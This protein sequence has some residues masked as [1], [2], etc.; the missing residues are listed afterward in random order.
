MLSRQDRSKEEKTVVR[1]M[2]VAIED[3]CRGEHLD[4]RFVGGMS[5]GGLLNN[6]TTYT[7]DV[8][9][10]RITLKNHNPL[11]LLRP[12]KS[13]RDIDFIL[14]S[15]APEKI[16]PLKRFLN[17]LKWQIRLKLSYTPPISFEGLAQYG[18]KPLGLLRFVTTMQIQRGVAY[19]VFDKISQAVSPE[20][21]EAWTVVLEDGTAYTTRNPIADY[22][23][24]QFRSPAGIKPKDHDKVARLKNL[25]DTMIVEGK[26]H[27]IDYMS[28]EYFAPWQTFIDDIQTS[29]IP[30]VKFN[31]MVTKL[32][33]STI[34]TTLA[35]GRGIGKPIFALFNF[36]T[37]HTQ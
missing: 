3:Y 7:I 21:L 34:G 25:V 4:H 20:S 5:Y 31:R 11:L 2:V 29:T 24:Y 32:Y 9:K 23:A 37:R 1:S 26:K 27:T 17:K 10:R 6:D 14:C 35:H 36:F 19:L 22:Y 16:Q 30:S 28:E 18:S 15:Y 13:V 8:P 33:W 12:D